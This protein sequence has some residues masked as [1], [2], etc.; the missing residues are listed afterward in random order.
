MVRGPVEPLGVDV[1]GAA[2]GEILAR[3]PLQLFWARFRR[4]RVAVASLAFIVVLV[5]VAIAAP[6]IVS[7]TGLPRAR[8]QDTAPRDP[9]FGVAPGRGAGPSSAHLLGVDGNGRDLL[10]RILYGARVSLTVA[11]VAT[12]LSMLAGVAAGMIAGYF[13]GWP[14]AVPSRLI[15][16]VLAVPLLL[17]PVG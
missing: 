9:D 17:L 14:P 11:L 7:A 1:P 3:S 13:R 16:A 12:F 15:D 4:D 2:D 5:L 10:S 8:E 6:L